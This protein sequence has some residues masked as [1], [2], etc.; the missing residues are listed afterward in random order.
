M[1]GRASHSQCGERALAV[2]GAG[3]GH[4]GIDIAAVPAHDAFPLPRR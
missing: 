1:T 2:A 3:A 4:A